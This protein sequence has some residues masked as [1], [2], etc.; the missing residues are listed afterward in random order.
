MMD[1]RE[2]E[3]Q[4]RAALRPVAAP[5]GLAERIVKRAE[6]RAAAKRKPLTQQPWLRW[7][8]LAAMLSIGTFGGLQW[9]QQRRAEQ[10]EAQ[11]A[12]EKFTLAMNIASSKIMR[13]QKNLVVEVPLTPG[14]IGQ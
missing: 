5:E 12:A 2:L 6:A 3:Q 14:G 4:L 7:G 11:R 10:D 13:L 9:N 1:E 8:A